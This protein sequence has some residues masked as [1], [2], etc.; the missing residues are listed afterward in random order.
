VIELDAARWPSVRLKG[1][2]LD[3]GGEPVPGA[4]LAPTF[5]D[6]LV[7][8]GPLLTTDEA[9]VFDLGPYPPGRWQ[10]VI[11]HGQASELC[12]ATVELAPGETWDFGDLQLPE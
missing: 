4:S 6:P 9:G 10:I 8:G 12:T 3:A 5:L 11:E 1:R 7:H 2:V